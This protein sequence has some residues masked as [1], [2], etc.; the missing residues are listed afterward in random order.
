[1]R[2]LYGAALRTVE[3]RHTTTITSQYA[4]SNTTV[5]SGFLNALVSDG[6]VFQ[7]AGPE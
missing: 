5:L 6:R 7:A 4:R 1:M 2:D 3:E